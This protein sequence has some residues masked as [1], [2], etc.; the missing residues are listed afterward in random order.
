SPTALYPE[1]DR[2]GVNVDW[3]DP[4]FLMLLFG[5]G[6]GVRRLFPAFAIGGAGPHGGEPTTKIPAVVPDWAWLLTS[7]GPQ[8]T[9]STLSLSAASVRTPYLPRTVPHPL[10]GSAIVE[11][12]FSFK[13]VDADPSELPVR[14]DVQLLA[15]TRNQFRVAR[16][17]GLEPVENVSR[18]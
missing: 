11:F 16:R 5:D 12:P 4:Q 3:L 2:G 8:A 13:G 14:I 1:F 10:D 17:A 7:L 15:F 18:F 9:G 6:D